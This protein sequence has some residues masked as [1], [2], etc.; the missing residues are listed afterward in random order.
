MKKHCTY[1]NHIWIINLYFPTPVLT[2]VPAPSKII[3]ILAPKAAAFDI[4]RVDGEARGFFRLFCIMQPAKDK[5]APANK[6]DIT[7]GK[8]MFF[9]IKLDFLSPKPNIARTVSPNFISVAPLFMDQKNA[10]VV[11]NINAKII[12]F[13]LIYILHMLYYLS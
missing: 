7:L 5:P 8:R 12:S 13:F 1:C 9:T 6:P 10:M 3:A 11:A 4:P 2:T